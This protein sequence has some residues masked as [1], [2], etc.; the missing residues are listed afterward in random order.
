LLGRAFP[1]AC[2]AWSSARAAALGGVPASSSRMPPGSVAV[3]AGAAGPG[4]VPAEAALGLEA[5]AT[6]G[7]APGGAAR[8]GGAPPPSRP[9]GAWPG[10]DVGGSPGGSGGSGWLRRGRLSP[11]GDLLGFFRGLLGRLRGH[12][13]GLRG[14]GGQR[15]SLRG[16][17]CH[18]V[19][20]DPFRG[21]SRSLG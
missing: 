19:F 2:S 5:G 4:A 8:G 16:L 10:S 6:A 13:L 20:A 7:A 3:M 15:L 11:F 9:G 14:L 12:R 1:D 17:G 18:V 21:R